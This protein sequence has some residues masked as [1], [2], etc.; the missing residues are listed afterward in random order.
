MEKKTEWIGTD[1]ETDTATPE[2]RD[3][4]ER[5]ELKIVEAEP[6]HARGEIELKPWHLNPFGIVHGGVLFTIADTVSGMAAITGKEYS[7]STIN[8]SIN[9]MRA[10]KNTK[11]ITAEG[12]VIK[13][14]KSLTV[15]ECKVYNDREEILA[16]AT[17]TFFHLPKG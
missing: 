14:G 11:K 3:F 6:G 12:Y 4:R 9:Y 5:V 17:M 2:M 8:G 7:V 16:V 15:C 10:G 1:T 13:D